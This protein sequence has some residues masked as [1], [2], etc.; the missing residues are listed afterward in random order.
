[1]RTV[2]ILFGV[3][4]EKVTRGDLLVVD[5]LS[6][7]R[8]SIDEAVFIIIKEIVTPLAHRRDDSCFLASLLG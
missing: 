5:I 8:S 1:L 4:D 3:M 2:P 7:L 6:N